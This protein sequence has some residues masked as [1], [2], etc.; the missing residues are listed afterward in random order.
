[1][2]YSNANNATHVN[3]SFVEPGFINHRFKLDSRCVPKK[4]EKPIA[5]QS[6]QI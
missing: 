1:M 4:L 3:D 5:C 2:S 6:P